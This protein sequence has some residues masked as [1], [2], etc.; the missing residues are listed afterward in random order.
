[1]SA[2]RWA[3]FVLAGILL[4]IS[5]IGTLQGAEYLWSTGVA[6][7][8]TMGSVLWVRHKDLKKK[9][10]A[11]SQVAASSSSASSDPAPPR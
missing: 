11:A 2:G 7:V 4:I 8:I 1:M 9:A 10:L 6:M 3:L 5:I